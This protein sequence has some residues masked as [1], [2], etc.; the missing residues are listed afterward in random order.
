MS[1]GV[2]YFSGPCG[3]SQTFTVTGPTAGTA[4]TAYLDSFNMMSPLICCVPESCS[5]TPFYVRFHLGRYSL[6][7]GCNITYIRYDPFTTLWP[8]QV[9]VYG[10]TPETYGSEW[11]ATQTPQCSNNCE[12]EVR[13]Y[14]RY[15]VS[16]YTF[17]HPWSNDTVVT[18]T[19]T[20]CGAG[21][22]NHLFNLTVPTCPIYCDS[23]FTVLNIPPP[24]ITDAC[25]TV[26][27][28][29][30]FETLP[31]IPA[32][33][34]DLVYDSVLCSGETALINLNSCLPNGTAHYYG[35][36]QS[37]QG[38]FSV[39][40]STSNAPLTLT[41]NA[42]AEGNGC[43]SD[44][45]TF[46]VTVYS[47]PTAA[48]VVNPSPVVAGIDASFQDQSTSPA[49]IIQ[50]WVWTLDDS[51]VSLTPQWNNLYLTPANHVLC[52]A[53]QD[54]VGCVDTLCSPFIVVPAEVATPNVI[55]P[56]NDGKNDLLAFEYLDFYPENQLRILNRWGAVVFE[57]TGYANTWDGDE[58]TDGVYF[59]VLTL[60][61]KNQTYSGFFHLIR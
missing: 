40:P 22:T 8:F 15:G 26:I 27:S 34:I 19:N 2:M 10:R 52:L 41:Y 5:P 28:N 16:P 49:S 35:E 4:G 7:A 33:N 21:S 1:Q 13:G 6:G 53:V 54:A 60:T 32:P 39:S 47:N 58:L 50:Q 37:G 42:Y 29:I 31:I 23:T 51:V 61:E 18:G 24:V 9:V 56:N 11:Y 30:G 48:Y 46:Q 59:Y 38:P 3:S 45:T 55:T 20:G 14:A 25:G 44:T 17:T 12:I 36:G 43:T 57:Q